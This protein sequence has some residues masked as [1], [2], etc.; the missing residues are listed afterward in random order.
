MKRWQM[1][2]NKKGAPEDAPAFLG[3]QLIDQECLGKFDD[4]WSS[5]LIGEEMSKD[6]VMSLDTELDKCTKQ[7]SMELLRP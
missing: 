7:I 2:P 1:A 3:P 5:K 6:K 4:M